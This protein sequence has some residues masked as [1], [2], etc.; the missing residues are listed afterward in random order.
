[1][2][3][4][5]ARA[6]IHGAVGG[7]GAGLVVAIWFLALDSAAG[8]PFLTPTLLAGVFLQ[9]SIEALQPTL[10][11]VLTY[12]LLH[13]GTFALLGA[14]TA[15]VL[16]LIGT[17]P[18]L[19]VG[20][21]FGVVV[22]NT[23]HYGSLLATDATF[24][25][26]LPVQYVLPAN[27]AG[28]MVLMTYLHFALYPAD[29]FGLAVLARHRFLV[30]GLG[31]G[32]AGAAVV[33]VWFFILDV[34]MARPFFTPAALGS[35]L[36]LGAA[37]PHAV[38]VSWGVVGAYTMLHVVAFAVVGL[39]FTW[40]GD[41]LARAPSIWLLAFIAFV[42]LEGVFVAVA[43]SVGAWVLGAVGWWAVGVGNLAAVLAMGKCVLIT[44]PGLEREL[45]RA[46]AS[47]SV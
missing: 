26:V 40:V 38:Q 23:V 5:L 37:S 22:L 31:T 36:F 35:T 27:L 16:E 18:G 3:R 41:Q 44:H 19:L 30:R 9:R 13:F 21:V 43:G 14:A 24:L 4:P 11:L 2:Q 42:V 29:P 34:V 46:T 7:I 28:G 8:Q 25:T 15:T 47:T 39:V 33:A 32:L 12:S 1:M 6:T 10:G 20:A 17:S 45:L